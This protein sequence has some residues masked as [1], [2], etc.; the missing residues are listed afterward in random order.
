VRVFSSM[1]SLFAPYG[2]GDLHFVTFSRYR[3]PLLPPPISWN[4]LTLAKE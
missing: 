3:R 1:R 2:R 4:E